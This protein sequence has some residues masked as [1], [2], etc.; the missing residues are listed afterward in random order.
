[1]IIS[2]SLAGSSYTFSGP[3]GGTANVASSNFTITPVGGTYT[4]DVTI[5]VSGGGLSTTITK[6]FTNSSAAQTFTLLRL[7]VRV[8]LC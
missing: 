2:A 7:Q 5:A 6:T 3:T 4:G 8:R 1:M